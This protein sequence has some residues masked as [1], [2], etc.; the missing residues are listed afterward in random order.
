MCGLCSNGELNTKNMCELYRTVSN[1]LSMESRC[2]LNKF[3]HYSFTKADIIYIHVKL[4]IYHSSNILHWISFIFASSSVVAV[5]LAKAKAMT[6][7]LGFFSNQ[8]LTKMKLS[9]FLEIKE[10]FMGC[11]SWNKHWIKKYWSSCKPGIKWIRVHLWPN[12]QCESWSLWR[13]YLT[14]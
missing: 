5:S 10:D 14:W 8:R 1:D 12:C 13:V 4:D 3:V 7:Y 9:D 6:E 11:Q 2:S